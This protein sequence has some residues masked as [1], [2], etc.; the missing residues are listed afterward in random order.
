MVFAGGLV[1]CGSTCASN[2]CCIHPDLRNVVAE[3]PAHAPHHG[4]KC[5]TVVNIREHYSV[6][7]A[8]ETECAVSVCDAKGGSITGKVCTHI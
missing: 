4:C 7:S 6:W 2:L 3:V 5:L 1:W 8:S